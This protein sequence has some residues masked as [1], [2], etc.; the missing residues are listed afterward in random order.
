[1]ALAAGK[2]AR[3]FASSDGET[4]AYR[5][6]HNAVRHLPCR[7]SALSTEEIYEFIIAVLMFLGE[8]R[9]EKIA[10]VPGGAFGLLRHLVADEE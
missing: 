2:Y 8:L 7:R 4:V 5:L 1:M 9:A 6:R 3:L 10:G